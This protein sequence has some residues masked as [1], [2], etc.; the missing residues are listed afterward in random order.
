MKNK[1]VPKNKVGEEGGWG[2]GQYAAFLDRLLHSGFNE[3][4]AT[5]WRIHA[6]VAENKWFRDFLVHGLWF[7]FNFKYN[8]W[9][10]HILIICIDFI[11]F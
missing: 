6:S 2:K 4:L 11:F 5:E 7:I 1:S 9:L 10:L 8:E 3:A